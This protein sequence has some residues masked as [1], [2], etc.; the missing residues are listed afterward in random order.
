MK[1]VFIAVFLVLGSFFVF[2]AGLGVFRFPDLYTRMHAATKASSFGIG[3]ML[4]GFLI[5][6]N[7]AYY[8]VEAILIIVFVFITAPVAAHMLSRAGYIL[9]VPKYEKMVV[10]EMADVYDDVEKEER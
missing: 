1:D 7:Q 9:N 4:V 2:L 6:F 5:R 10:D 3:L 8:V